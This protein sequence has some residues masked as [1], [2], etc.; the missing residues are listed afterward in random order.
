MFTFKRTY[1]KDLIAAIARDP[2]VNRAFAQGNRDFVPAMES[3]VRY[4]LVYE[5]EHLM[6]FV[7]M[8]PRWSPACMEIDHCLPWA[9]TRKLEAAAK[10]F[11]DWVWFC[12]PQVHCLIGLTPKDNRAACLFARRIG[13]KVLGE[14]PTAFR[15][16]GGGLVGL[17][18]SYLER[19]HE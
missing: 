17:Q 10:A 16:G 11:F 8:C 19:P 2:K 18:V 5:D 7:G 15:T 14:L 6:G 3:E 12:F 1:N 9:D 4:I 13:M